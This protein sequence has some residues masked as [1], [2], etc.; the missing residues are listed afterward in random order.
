MRTLKDL[1]NLDVEA[2]AKAIEADAGESIPDLRQALVEAKAGK[3]AASHT[4]EQIAA[5]KRGRPL[6][7]VAEE[8]KAKG[9]LAGVW[10]GLAITRQL[11]VARGSGCRKNLKC[12][13]AHLTAAP[14]VCLLK[15]S[16]P[17]DKSGL[18][19]HQTQG[20]SIR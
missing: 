1:Q 4:P 9:A 8:T 17:H 7:S 20:R 2:V 10:Q 14:H 19:P 5:R 12:E 16:I 13:A 11:R 6:G 15:R 3:F 18:N